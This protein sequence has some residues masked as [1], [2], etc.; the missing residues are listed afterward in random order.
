VNAFA[1]GSDNR[2][3]SYDFTLHD[4]LRMALTLGVVRGRDV[5]V[6]CSERSTTASVVTLMT[7]LGYQLPPVI[8]R[9]NISAGLRDA[10][11]NLEHL[12]AYLTVN[13]SPMSIVM[14]QPFLAPQISQQFRIDPQL[15]TRLND[16]IEFFN[17]IPEARPPQRYLACPTSELISAQFPGKHCVLKISSSA[18]AEGVHLCPTQAAWDAAVQTAQDFPTSQ[19]IAE[20]YVDACRNLDVEFYVPEDPA[21][22]PQMLGCVE[23]ICVSATDIRLAG[24][25][26]QPPSPC[27]TIAKISRD[28]LHVI[29]PKLRSLGWHG[30]GGFDILV[31]HAGREFYIDPNLRF[32]DFTAPLIRSVQLLPNQSLLILPNARF[33]GTVAEFKLAFGKYCRENDPKQILTLHAMLELDGE[34]VVYGGLIFSSKSELRT[35]AERLKRKGLQARPLEMISSIVISDCMGVE[36]RRPTAHENDSANLELKLSA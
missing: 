34:V 6:L 21:L 23:Q 3:Y 27:E 14:S 5:S 28:L 24:G 17:L 2:H 12:S 31:D 4:E 25:V 16:K 10:Q 9:C 32:T 13:S 26:C 8:Q 1:F 7:E 15:Q 18:G 30:I 33:K 35:R 36:K 22:P 19:A 29:L 20:E 11:T